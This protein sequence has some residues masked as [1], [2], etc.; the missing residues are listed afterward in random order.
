MDN[1]IPISLEI[2]DSVSLVDHNLKFDKEPKLEGVREWIVLISGALLVLMC[3]SAGYKIY[4]TKRKFSFDCIILFSE[5]FK[6]FVLL[7]YE[8]VW[9]HLFMLLCV[10]I[11]DSILRAVIS[12][13]FV[14]R[15]MILKKTDPRKI[16][17][18]Q[19]GY[20]L[21]IAAVLVGLIT[22]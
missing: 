22:L 13:N 7:A 17:R 11:V 16:A 8:F 14:S 5:S 19:M 1:R 6:L 12:A 9:D 21:I 10:L 20:Y 3:W 15:A 18:F 2:P 4:K